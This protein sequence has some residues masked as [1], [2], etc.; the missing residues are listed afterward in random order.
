M[1][2][3]YV[4]SNCSQKKY[5]ELF[6]RSN[7]MILQQ[8]Q[9]YH[10]LLIE[11]IINNGV[12]VTCISGLPVNRN[13]TKS[14]VIRGE[15]ENTE[16]VSYI[17]Y[18]TLNL[19][20]LRQLGI[21]MNGFLKTIHFCRQNKDAVIICDILNIANSSGALLAAKI[22]RKSTLGI[23]T[24][25]PGILANNSQ[26]QLGIRKLK[27]DVITAANQFILHRFDSYVFLT[28]PMNKLINREK[29]PFI[30]LEG[31]ADLKMQNMATF[32]PK[33][34]D[35]K[36]VM[37]A[38]SLKK[39][40]G[41]G[42]LTEAFIKVGVEDSELHIYGDGDF[43]EKLSKICKEHSSIKYFGVKP[44]GYIVNEQLRATL[45]VNP[46]PTGEEYTK[47]SYPS[48]NM[49]YMV[50]GTPT[51]TTKL[52]GMPVEY[53]DYVYLIEKETVDGIS[54]ALKECLLRSQEELNE[55]GSRAK[56]FVLKEK[57]NVVQAKKII[58][59]I[60]EL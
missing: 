26:V 16:G 37:Y 1:K 21:F 57:N 17:Y 51:L 43:A 59:M 48:K 50:S 24:D 23:V 53:N 9:K 2:I 27:N 6:S 58:E 4:Y 22:C 40:Y 35:K 54:A 12:E 49:E 41:I 45:L 14:L 29:R 32:F 25:V 52:P 60:I 56:Q 5:N 3:L 39:I 20:I 38:G 55:K 46:R 33:K 30:I 19:P 42:M 47:Y 15:T 11:G 44:N 13:L 36:V 34:Y 31:H 28:E 18:S 8:A 7:E 10:S